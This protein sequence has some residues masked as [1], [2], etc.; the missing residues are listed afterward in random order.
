MTALPDRAGPETLPAWSRTDRAR[1]RGRSPRRL[2][3]GGSPVLLLFAAMMAIVLGTGA[4][5]APL[6]TLAVSITAAA[7]ALAFAA[8]WTWRTVFLF[9]LAGLLLAYAFLGRGVAHVGLGVAYI[10]EVGL[11]LAVIA[12]VSAWRRVSLGPMQWLLI[13]F[14]AWGLLRMVP[15]LGDYGIDA[16]RDAVIWIYAL[17]ALSLSV[18]VEGR[19]FPRIVDWYRRLL[20]VFLLWVPVAFILTY[21]A[22]PLPTA[23]GSDVPIIVFKGGDMGVHL[24]GAA[25]F[26]LVGLAFSPGLTSQVRQVLLW[27]L[28]LVDVAIVGGV[29]RGGLLASAAAL[30]TLL[31]SRVSARWFSLV[32][33]AVVLASGA[34]L[35]DP[36]VDTGADRNVSVQQVVDNVASIFSSD[37]GSTVLQ[38]SK[39]FRI[40]WWSEIVG[41]TFGGQYFAAGKGFGIN[42]ADDDGFQTDGTLRAP[43]NGHMTILAR[44]GV[45][46]LIIWVIL[47]AMF[48]WSILRAGISAYRAG[49]TFWTQVLGWILTYWLAAIINMSFDPYLEGPQGGI[50]FWSMF[51]LGLAAIAVVR[52]LLAADTP[53]GK[54]MA[55]SA[56]PSP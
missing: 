28:W 45:P 12:L 20:P 6:P 44:E 19:H 43:H 7:L 24:A 14:M 2:L 36:E 39:D 35:L 31:F 26:M 48:G 56:E 3:A 41:Y 33:V 55:L 15:Y 37:V 8:R 27:A 17:I 10:G 40:Q 13:L 42:L 29:N 11:L 16:I 21:F 32:F 47:Q 38:G 51:G 53:A 1:F 49:L 46:G 52:R 9:V 50:W 18:V 5:I 54:P 30:A 4:V 25:A 22:V 23:P 34:A